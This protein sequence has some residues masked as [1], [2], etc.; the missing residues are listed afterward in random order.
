[1][2]KTVKVQPIV[3]FQYE[4]KDRKPN[5]DPFDMDEKTANALKDKG[6]VKIIPAAASN[7]KPSE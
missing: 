1:M 4:G 6:I 7:Q 5:S 3:E 2:A